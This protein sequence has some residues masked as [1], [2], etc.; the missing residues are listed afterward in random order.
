MSQISGRIV[1][2]AAVTARTPV[3]ISAAATVA[4]ASVISWELGQVARSPL[5]PGARRLHRQYREL[6][7]RPR[8]APEA[9]PARTQ[10]TQP[11]YDER[12]Q[13]A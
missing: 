5:T 4:A 7:A 3:L 9:Q 1:R 8:H 13:A 10:I 2:L 11:L 6:A 12:R